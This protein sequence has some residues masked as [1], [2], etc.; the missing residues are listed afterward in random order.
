MELLKTTRYDLLTITFI[1]LQHSQGHKRY[2]FYVSKR[3]N[4]VFTLSHS[5][6]RERSISQ[7]T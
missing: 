7:V 2:F 6:C 5:L 1:T 3:L 4:S